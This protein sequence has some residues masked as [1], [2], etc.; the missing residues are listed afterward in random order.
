MFRALLCFIVRRSNCIIQHL[1][2]S[3][4]VGGRTATY[5]VWRYQMLYNTIWPPDDEAQQ[6][7][8]HV[9]EYAEQ[10]VHRTATYRVWRYQMLYNTIWPPDDEAQQCSKHVEEYNNFYIHGSVLRESNFIIVQQ[11]ATYSVY[12]H[13]CRQ[14]YT[15]RMLTPI[16]RS[17][18]SCNYSFWYWITG[19]T[20]ARSRCWVGTDTL[21]SVPTQQ[22]ERIV[23]DTVDQ[24]Q[25]L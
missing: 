6:C 2:L 15:F 8:K 18:Y 7:S 13:F 20:A 21:E 14:L 12:L 16:I 4:C 10:P 25:K 11:E 5:T 17:S 22:R 23:V 24:C 19:S 9:E 1:V 3:H